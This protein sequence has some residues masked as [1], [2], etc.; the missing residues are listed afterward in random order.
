MKKLF[1]AL[2]LTFFALQI[3]Q[4]QEVKTEIE[5]K[6]EVKTIFLTVDAD[7]FQDLQGFDWRSTLTEIFKDVPD[8]ATVGIRINIGAK[9]LTN[10]IATLNNKMSLEEI[11]LAKNKEIMLRRIVKNVQYFIE[12]EQQGYNV[13]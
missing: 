6:N 1:S 12:D 13:D 4:A 8:H 11:G 2:L 10:D 5:V 7:R 9:Q 3:T